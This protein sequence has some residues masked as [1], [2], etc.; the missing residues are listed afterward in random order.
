MT[1][2]EKNNENKKDK[3]KA[4]CT[5]A[6]GFACGLVKKFMALRD[7]KTKVFY[8]AIGGALLLL[9]VIVYSGGNPEIISERSAK[10]FKVGQIYT[11]NN[12]NAAGGQAMTSIIKEPCVLQGYDRSQNDD[13]YVCLAPSGS[14]VKILQLADAY[15]VASLCAKVKVESGVCQGKEGWTLTN[16]IN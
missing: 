14:K 2:E 9:L 5:L 6:C 7:S 11:L 10:V 8:G 12:P 1:T 16:N 3:L 4:A 15:G 13:L